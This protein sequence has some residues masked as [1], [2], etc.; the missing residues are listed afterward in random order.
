M[1]REPG[2]VG[3]VNVG[4]PMMARPWTRWQNWANVVLG[5]LL[6]ISP[7]VYG[8]QNHLAF[9]PYAHAG[10]NAWIIGVAI[11]IIALWALDAPRSFIPEWINLLLGIW[12]FIS[13][14][15]LGFAGLT[16]SA[17]TSWILGILVVIAAIW[18]LM[19]VQRLNRVPAA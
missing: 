4:S 8:V 3:S 17:W 6:F 11:T 13:P 9:T 10:W 7:W 5:I 15:V 19:E 2:N 16:A 18:A 14:W 1:M 12:L